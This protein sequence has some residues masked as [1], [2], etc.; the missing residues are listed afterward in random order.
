MRIGTAVVPPPSQPVE[1]GQ[2][3][4]SAVDKA[5]LNC[6]AF[7]SPPP[8]DRRRVIRAARWI[9]CDTVV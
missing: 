7:A 8:A 4:G 3:A 6:D 1:N 9:G 2:A 5:V